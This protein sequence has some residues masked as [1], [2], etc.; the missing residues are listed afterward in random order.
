MRFKKDDLFLKKL[1]LRLRK[2]RNDRGWTLEETEEYGWPSWKHLQRIES[3]KNVTALTL[4]KISELYEMP[5]SE[6][7]D[8]I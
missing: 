5:L 6:I 2:I 3:G 8:G 4:L 1:G 7:F